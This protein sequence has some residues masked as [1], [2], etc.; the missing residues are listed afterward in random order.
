MCRLESNVCSSRMLV[1]LS[2]VAGVLSLAAMPSA[3]R[4][5]CAGPTPSVIWSYPAQD[6]VDVPF[7]ADLLMVTEG[8]WAD[9][10][11]TLDGE[12]VPAGSDVPGHYDLGLMQP[13]TTYTVAII[14]SDA[15]PTPE[16]DLSWQF[17][18]GDALA[19]EDVADV[20]SVLS[21][22]ARVIDWSEELE[23]DRALLANT[24]FDTGAP[25]LHA[26]E[27]DADAVLWAVELVQQSGASMWNI[28]PGDCGQP[29]TL[30]YPWDHT[31]R[32]LRIHA[33]RRDG[34]MASSEPFVLPLEPL[35]PLDGGS[36][37]EGPAEPGDADVIEP[38]SSGAELGGMDE[39]GAPSGACAVTQAGRG[40]GSFVAL[41][42]AAAW[43]V[44]R[45]RMVCAAR[46]RARRAR[47]ASRFTP[48]AGCPGRASVRL[49]A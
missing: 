32:Q 45:R 20:V 31:Y 23:C 36:L 14:S 49:G 2:C 7:D 5:S 4:A 1:A 15:H 12:L 35:E 9:A 21:A 24:C 13:N 43:L 44:L 6:Q 42:G 48:G 26:F 34:S 30:S 41:L 16:V 40:D 46:C 3:A 22:S 37:E 27:T 11:V 8:I 28:Y 25:T 29:R 38:G 18:T 47:A 33:I 39:A 17:T 19:E 10:R